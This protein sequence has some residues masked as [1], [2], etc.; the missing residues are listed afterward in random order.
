MSA[1]EHS[2]RYP[3]HQ[4]DGLASFEGADDDEELRRA[5]AMSEEEARAPKRHKREHTPEEERKMLAEWVNSQF[6]KQRLTEAGP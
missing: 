5:I 6:Q 3:E 1:R 2:D 4:V